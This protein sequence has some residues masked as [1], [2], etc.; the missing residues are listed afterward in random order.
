MGYDFVNNPDNVV[1]TYLVDN[2]YSIQIIRWILKAINLWPRSADISIV[3]KALSK[4][5]IF[6]CYFLMIAIMIPEWSEYLYGVAGYLRGQ[7]A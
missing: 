7:V 1:S 5:L 3:E 4:F 6:I 2:E